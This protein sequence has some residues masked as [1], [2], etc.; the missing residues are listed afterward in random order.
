MIFLASQISAGMIH[1]KR[2]LSGY[3][4]NPT[5]GLE[6]TPLNLQN[7]VDLSGDNHSE[8]FY[9]PL[10]SLITAITDPDRIVDWLVQ[11]QL[12]IA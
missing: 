3:L 2:L 4:P 9:S 1:Q 11:L 8:R 12:E 7:N 6:S 5:G 10:P